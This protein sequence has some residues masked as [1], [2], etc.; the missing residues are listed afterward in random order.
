MPVS[1]MLWL[2]ADIIAVTNLVYFF[3]F[4]KL[5]LEFFVIAYLQPIMFFFNVLPIFSF[6]SE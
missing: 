1:A 5:F 6:F 4:L 3:V 2:F